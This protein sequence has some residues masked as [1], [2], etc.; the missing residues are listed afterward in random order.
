[1]GRFEGARWSVDDVGA[2]LRLYRQYRDLWH[3][4][5]GSRVQDLL[6]RVVDATGARHILVLGAGT[7]IRFPPELDERMTVVD[8]S[9]DVRE[10]WSSEGRNVRFVLDD[11]VRAAHLLVKDHDLVVLPAIL[12]WLPEKKRMDLRNV[13]KPALDAGKI[14]LA[15]DTTHHSTGYEGTRRKA[16]QVLPSNWH[17]LYVGGS[18]LVL[19]CCVWV[20]S[21]RPLLSPGHL[22]DPG[23]EWGV[24]ASIHGPRRI[25]QRIEPLVVPIARKGYRE[26]AEHSDD[27]RRYVEMKHSRWLRKAL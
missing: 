12:S 7:P 2:L 20:V 18:R 26:W 4:T 10:L 24:E 9:P 13:L 19:P 17:D 22:V 5:Y 3:Q 1:M 21:P 11:V 14:V 16:S 6:R 8:R 15:Y 23:E 25:L 27:L